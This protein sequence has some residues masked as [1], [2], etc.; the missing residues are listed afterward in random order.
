MGGADHRM[1][2]QIDL[3]D[4]ERARCLSLA[5]V[6]FTYFE[7]WTNELLAYAVGVATGASEETTLVFEASS[8]PAL[9][10]IS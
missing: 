8:R 1:L 3:T 6:V 2:A 9:R 7:E 4:G 10:R 5:R